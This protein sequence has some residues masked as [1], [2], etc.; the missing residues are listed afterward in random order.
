MTR[1]KYKLIIFS[2]FVILH[3]FKNLH[4]ADS[5]F[6]DDFSN[7]PVGSITTGAMTSQLPA[8]GT[9]WGIGSGSGNLNIGFDSKYNNILEAGCT[10]CP[11][12]T[13]IIETNFPDNYS[14]RF[15]RLQL[16]LQLD[17]SSEVEIFARSLG[18]PGQTAYQ[19]LLKN[20]TVTVNSNLTSMSYP[21]GSWFL[22]EVQSKLNSD[23]NECSNYLCVTAYVN[24]V[25]TG[26]YNSI[27]NF[28]NIGPNAGANGFITFG[29]I[30][31]I[32]GN[33]KL[34]NVSMQRSAT[35]FI[36]PSNNGESSPVLAPNKFIASKHAGVQFFNLNGNADVKIYDLSGELKYQKTNVSPGEIWDVK[37]NT[38][39]NLRSGIY[40][41]VIQTS[42]GETHRLKLAVIR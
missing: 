30:R 10:S 26:V 25:S 9:G 35:A 28:Q 40:F 12:T 4:A 14:D 3:N 19:I 23:S 13:W 1:P 21:I 24:R 27:G 42:S 7:Y 34:G 39:Q 6:T 41:V 18:P 22:L 17:S 2:V 33:L 20:G 36:L 8:A 11:G 29:E 32:N 38:G 5:L 15:T 16:P 31:I 37:S